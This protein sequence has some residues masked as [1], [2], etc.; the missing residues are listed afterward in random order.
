MPHA[1]YRTI[2]LI[3]GL[4]ALVVILAYFLVVSIHTYLWWTSYILPSTTELLHTL[5]DAFFVCALIYACAMTVGTLY[6]LIRKNT[7]T[8]LRES[9]WI[10]GLLGGMIP[11]AFVDVDFVKTIISNPDILHDGE[12][13]MVIYVLMLS[14]AKLTLPVGIAAGALIG[15]VAQRLQKGI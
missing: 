14:L 11:P 4:M 1:P 13:G 6:F 3:L 2:R 12:Y 7:H 10:C 5:I 8:V 9:L 15:A